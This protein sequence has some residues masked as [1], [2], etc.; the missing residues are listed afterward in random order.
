MKEKSTFI[1]EE[2]KDLAEKILEQFSRFL[3]EDFN[4]D[5]FF[6]IRTEGVKPKWV[7]KV[8]KIGHPWGSLPGLDDMIYLVETASENWELLNE[9]Q[10]TLVVFHEMK[11]IPEGGCD[12]DSAECGKVVDHPIQDFP[13]CIAAA[14]GNLFWYEPEHG[15]ELPNILLTGSKFDLE[16]ALKRTGFIEDEDRKELIEPNEEEDDMAASMIGD[17]KDRK[18]KEEVVKISRT[19]AHI[20]EKE[21]SAEKSVDVDEV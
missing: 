8:R 2:F 14:K 10:R 12:F 16:A 5:R 9:A 7:S 4:L 19:A 3:P 20:L 11:H 1:D 6:F 15:E 21:E 18:D 17:M 13:E